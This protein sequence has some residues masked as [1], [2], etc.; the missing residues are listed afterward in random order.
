MPH[1]YYHG[2]PKDGQRQDRVDAPGTI[3]FPIGPGTP[4]TDEA[5]PRIWKAVYR[6]SGPD[7]N[8]YDFVDLAKP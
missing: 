7:S 6:K 2:G 8:H 3:Q 5:A 4:Q 1:V